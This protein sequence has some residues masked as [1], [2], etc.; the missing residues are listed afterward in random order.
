MLDNK[1]IGKNILDLRRGLELTQVELSTLLGVSHQ[2][3]SKWKQG[4]CLP[5][6]EVLLR[7]GQIFNKSI[8]ELLMSERITDDVFLVEEVDHSIVSLDQPNLW[9]KALEEIRDQISIPSF[10]TW[11]RNTNA[12]YVDGV[13][14][15]TSPNNSITEWLYSRYSSLIIKTLEGL[16]GETDFKIEFRSMDTNNRGNGMMPSRTTL[17]LESM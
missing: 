9:I 14:L 3:V 4:E 1:K 17:N 8:E 16:T 15:I 12:V 6:I 7:L 5:D 10:N 2:A 13:F 11:L